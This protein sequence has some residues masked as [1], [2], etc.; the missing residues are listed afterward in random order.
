MCDHKSSGG[1]FLKGAFWGAV[2]GAVLGVLYAPAPG[3]ETR[4]KLKVAQDEYSV[5]GKKLLDDANVLVEDA[6]V[7]AGPLIKEVEEKVAPVFEKV[8]E[9]SGPVKDEVMEAIDQ[10]VE[11]IDGGERR[12]SSKSGSNVKK[13]FFKGTKKS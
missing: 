9:Q 5:K 1:A 12:N 8:R 13:R 7:A 4:K 3:E 11:T 10:L 6:K 2:V